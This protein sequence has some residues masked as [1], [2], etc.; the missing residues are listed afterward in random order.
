M[1]KPRVIATEQRG[2]RLTPCECD[3]END[4]VSNT[5]NGKYEYRRSGLA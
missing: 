4:T 1:S 5:H 3:I 2:S